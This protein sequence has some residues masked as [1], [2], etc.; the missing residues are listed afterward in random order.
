[1]P[2]ELV[3]QNEFNHHQQSIN[4]LILRNF[5][6]TGFYFPPHLHYFTPRPSLLLE[7]MTPHGKQQKLKPG[8]SSLFFFDKAMKYLLLALSF[9]ALSI[10]FP[11][12]AS[13]LCI[14]NHHNQSPQSVLVDNNMQDFSASKTGKST[15]HQRMSSEAHSEENTDNSIN[16][17]SPAT[18][19]SG[20]NHVRS[21]VFE[22]ASLVGELCSLFL[23]RVP[24]DSPYVPLPPASLAEEQVEAATNNNDD[25]AFSISRPNKIDDKDVARMMGSVLLKLIELGHSLN[26]QLGTVIQRKMSLNAKKYPADLCRGKSGKYTEYS[27]VTGITKEEGQSLLHFGECEESETVLGFL[28]SLEGLTQDIGN[29]AGERHW[30]RYHKPRNLVLALLGELGEVSTTHLDG[31]LPLLFALT[32]LNRFRHTCRCSL[33]RSFSGVATAPPLTVLQRKTWTRSAK[34]WLMLPSI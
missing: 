15:F 29:F 32:K 23:K 13:F 7:A 3:V 24:L 2:V 27:S 34:N 11:L 5:I 25:E 19:T 4:H 21:L 9:V 30:T 8:L 12:I 33:L 20:I 10:K 1:M 28:E 18:H 17:S 26:L 14:M 22:L 16:A 31:S 6:S